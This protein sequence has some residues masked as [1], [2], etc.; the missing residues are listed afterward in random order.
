MIPRSASK[1]YMKLAASLDAKSCEFYFRVL[2][3]FH[4]RIF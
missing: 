2:L 3:K 1:R 4:V